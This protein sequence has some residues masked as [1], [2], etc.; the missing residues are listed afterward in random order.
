MGSMV[1]PAPLSFSED[2]NM[3]GGMIR[4]LYGAYLDEIIQR[5]SEDYDPYEYVEEDDPKKAS[6]LCAEIVENREECC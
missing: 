3:F 4:S 6:Q 5:V 2:T 1:R